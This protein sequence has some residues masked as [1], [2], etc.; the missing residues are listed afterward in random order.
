MKTILTLLLSFFATFSF[1]QKISGTLKS[2]LDEPIPYAAVTINSPLDSSLVKATISN[3]D[4]TFALVGMLPSEYLFN[5]SA[6]GYSDH[7]KKINYVGGDLVLKPIVMTEAAQNLEEVTVVAEKPMV[8]VLADKT[9]F[10]VQNTINATGTSAFELLR[11]APGV[12]VDN[13]GGFI[14]EGKTGVQIFI[15]GK[16]SILQGEDLI[17]FLESLQATDIEAVEI[18]TQPSSKYDAAGNAGIINIKLKKD[19][20]LGT[21]GTY[22]TGVTTGDF[23]RYNSSINFNNRGKKGNLYGTYSNRFGKTTGFIN[24]L[25]TQS[26][27]QF[28]ARTT[29]IYDRNSNNIKLGY[30]YYLDSKHTI[31]AIFNGNF[32]NSFNTNNTRT[33]IRP[34]GIA[35]L[36]SVLVA[37]NQVDNTS[38]NINAN[39]NYKYADTLGRSLNVDLDYGG[40]NSDRNA[41]QPNTFFD[42]SESVVFRE[43]ITFQETPIDIEIGTAKVDYEQNF[44]KG[45][46]GVGFKFSYVDTDNTFNFFNEINGQNVLDDTQ[47]NEFR[48]TENI[49]AGYFNYNRKWGKWNLQFG[50]RVE[51]TVSDG[52]L[53]STQ[54]NENNRVERN[55]TDF[56]PS[57]GLTYQLNRKNQFALNY[58]RRIQRPNYQSLNPFQFRLN[59]LS[60]SEGNPFLQPQYTNNVKLSHTFNYRLTTSISYSRITDFFARV[61]LEESESIS[62]LTTLNVANQE[63]FNLG[64]SYPKKLFSWWDVYVSVNAFISDYQA[65]SPEFLP[66]RQETLNFYGQN[67]FTLRNDWR[68]EVSGWY[69]SPSIWGGTY[70]TD[71]LGSLNAAVQKKFMDGRF[72]ARLAVNDILFTSPWSGITQFG[73]LFIDG[74]GGSDS[75]RV[76]FGLTYDFGRNEIKKS[77]K[78]KTGLEDENKRIGS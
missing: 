9:V 76:A 3:E 8:Q 65:T 5:V 69:N 19:K 63:V 40:Y 44:L 25:R 31:G 46:L 53:E 33:P 68:F 26:N 60:F 52:N 36:D 61:T 74:S 15:D 16:L 32:N 41:F 7:N 24:L 38:Y 56:F 2:A 49:N 54:E 4:G 34:A 71:S 14:V 28:D 58:S 6:L 67:T 12:I 75:R 72:T 23:A 62:N 18:I 17:N 45:K 59:E 1:G 48:Y 10:N 13:D 55:F 22:N 78:R 70:Q 29:S 42:P 50:L 47:S 57:G 77:R 37:L 39:I 64:V 30:D 20:S 11:K 35:E 27:T 73:E 21:N 66:V 43:T 51:N